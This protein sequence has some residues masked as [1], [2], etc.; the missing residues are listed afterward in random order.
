MH[1]RVETANCRAVA[2]PASTPKKTLQHQE[3]HDMGYLQALVGGGGRILLS[4]SDKAYASPGKM[5]SMF[6]RDRTRSRAPLCCRL[7]AI[8]N[9]HLEC[10]VMLPTAL[11][12]CDLQLDQRTVGT[13]SYSRNLISSG[14]MCGIT[15][16]VPSCTCWKWLQL[17]YRS[18]RAPCPSEGRVPP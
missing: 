7:S 15:L 8:V 2:R 11:L 18:A 16:D 14:T 12:Q 5:S 1:V 6:L 3:S 9:K 10:S 17:S 4:C 13:A